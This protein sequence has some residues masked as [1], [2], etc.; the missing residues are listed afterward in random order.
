MTNVGIM[1]LAEMQRLT[2]LNLAGRAAVG[3]GGLRWLET[4]GELRH[5]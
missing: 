3:S 5:L 2:Q 1:A 4:C